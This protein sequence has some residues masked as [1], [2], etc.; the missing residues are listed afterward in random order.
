MEEASPEAGER[1]AAMD[2]LAA[3][4]RLERLIRRRASFAWLLT[5]IMVAIYVG[6]I[7]L[8][9]FRPDIVALPIGSGV[10]S[11]GIPLGV[12]VILAGI[13]LTGIYVRR[14]NRDFD[15]EMAAIRREHGL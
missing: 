3:D 14:A 10:T 5:V 6:Y 13:L 7:L 2:A 15:S 9:A 1:Q 12:G 4:P 11:L 8:V